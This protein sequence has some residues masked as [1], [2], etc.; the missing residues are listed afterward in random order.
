[1][2]DSHIHLDELPNWLVRQGSDA[3][4]FRDEA[5]QAL[6]W[7]QYTHK[8]VLESANTATFLISEIT[9]S[10]HFIPGEREVFDAVRDFAY[11]Y[12]NYCHRAYILREKSCQYI[13]AVL[14]IG[15]KPREVKIKNLKMHSEVRVSGMLAAL[16][17]FDSTKRGALGGLIKQR[18][19]MTHNS[20]YAIND[21]L[22]RPS[23][24][25]TIS[26]PDDFRK[27]AKGWSRNIKAKSK[28][29]DAAQHQL[30]HVNHILAESALKY[31]KSQKKSKQ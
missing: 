17:K 22:L 29:V 31:R 6:L 30:D 19:N 10:S 9:S 2:S 27:W 15:Y 21:Q 11:H 4:K 13:N 20:F 14:G 23:G 16:D 26:S 1:M 25:S 28:D 18:S 8:E 12:E 5:Y 7:L 24:G 3:R